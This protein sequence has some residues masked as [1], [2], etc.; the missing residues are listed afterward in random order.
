MEQ[1]YHLKNEIDEEKYL[2]K[3]KKLLSYNRYKQVDER[4]YKLI[5]NQEILSLKK[6]EKNSNDKNPWKLLKEGSN[7]HGTISKSQNLMNGDKDEILRKYAN[8]KIKREE[9]IKK[10]PRFDSVPIFLIKKN[11][12]KI[13]FQFNKPKN[14]IKSDSFLLDKKEW[15]SLRMSKDNASYFLKNKKI[16]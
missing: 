5:S 14:I 3:L 11:K 7:E 12:N 1:Y 2:D 10:L 8:A 15:F 16:E 6:D 4:G 13:N 9:K